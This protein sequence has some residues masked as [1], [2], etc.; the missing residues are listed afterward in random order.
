MWCLILYVNLMGLRDT[1]K[2]GT[3]LFLCVSVRM[4]SKKISIWIGELNKVDCS[5]QRRWAAFSPLRAQIGWKG[6]WRVNLPSPVELGHPSSPALGY[7]CSPVLKLLNWDWDTHHWLLWFLGLWTW[8]EWYHQLSWFSSLQTAGWVISQ[9]PKLCESMPIIN[10]LL[11][12]FLRRTLT[13][14]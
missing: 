2:A 3:T 1:Q 13:K 11:A 9:L 14:T 8:T 12:L 10:I 5:P 6:R 4:F 7:Q